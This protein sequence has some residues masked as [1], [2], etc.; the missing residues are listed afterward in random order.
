MCEYCHKYICPSACPNAP[1]PPVFAKCSA[2]GAEIY[3]GEDYYEIFDEC[4]CLDCVFDAR[5][6]A[7]V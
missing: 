6:T 4:I 2:C 5:K 3:D 1:D 7:E